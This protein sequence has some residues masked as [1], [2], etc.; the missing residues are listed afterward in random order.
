M[1]RYRKTITAIFG[2]IVLVATMYT[3]GQWSPQ[4]TILALEGFGLALG[5]YAVPNAPG[6]PLRRQ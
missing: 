1:E 4:D 2:W 5:I 3:D 6:D